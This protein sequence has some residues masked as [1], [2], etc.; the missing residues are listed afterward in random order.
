EAE[1]TR[2]LDGL[3]AN[4]KPSL[5]ENVRRSLQAETHLEIATAPSWRGEGAVDVK[6]LFACANGL[7]N[8]RT[9]AL[10]PHTPEY[11]NLNWTDIHYDPEATCPAW[12]QFI[13]Q[14]YPDDEQAVTLLQDW[15]G[16]CLTDD[17]SQQKMLMMIGVKRSGKGTIARVAQALVGP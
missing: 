12:E 8:L 1:I 16:Y 5:V 7:L 17:T 15:L 2:F 10:I 3:G 4:A 6:D 9:G 13:A 14:V 11:F